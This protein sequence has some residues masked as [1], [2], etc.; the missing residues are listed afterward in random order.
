MTDAEPLAVF[1]NEHLVRLAPPVTA[2]AAAR[3]HDPA[4]VEALDSGRAYVTD[5]RGIR[6]DPDAPLEPGAIVRVV[7]SARRPGSDA[8]A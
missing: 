1:V 7:V 5:G 8:D 4:L 2:R 6:C 3:A